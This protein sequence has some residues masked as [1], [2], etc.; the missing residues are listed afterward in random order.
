LAILIC[1]MGM[2]LS[3]SNAGA[4][5][6]VR[7]EIPSSPNPVGSG[8]RAMGMG[9]AFIAIAD[10][11]TAAS[12]NPGGLIQ[13]EKPE[14]S[15][16]G[17]YVYRS[18]NNSF[19]N[20][21]EASG[22][23]STD[24]VNLNYLSGAYP[25]KAFGHNMIVSLNYQRLYDFYRNW[26]FSLNMNGPPFVGPV[27]Y[28]YDQKGALYALGLAYSV[29]IMPSFS[30][31]LTINYWGDFIFANKWEQKYNQKAR[32]QLGPFPGTS[33]S[34][35]TEKY[36]FDGW[37]ANFGFLWRMTEHWTL[38]CVFKTPFTANVA[39]EINSQDTTVFPTF[40]AANTS[41][42]THLTF[43]DK[44]QMPMSYGLGLAYRF[45][46]K[47]TLSGDV[48]RTHWNDFTYKNYQGV[49]TSPISGKAKG[50]SSIAPTMWLRFGGEYLIIRE[51]YVVPLRAGI[52][53]DPAPAEGSP[54]KFY[55]FAVGSGISYG[56]FVFDI[57]YQFRFGNGVGSSTLPGTNFSQDVREHTVYSSLIIHF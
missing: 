44:L 39:H 4:Q 11:A 57:A 34:D 40:P 18:E 28:N 52:F 1:L 51:K 53:Y 42:T 25:F 56:R 3:F 31:G 12:W 23:Q 2:L 32:I 49:E 7:M 8:A 37:N 19:G 15:F 14:I 20:N 16:V 17:G 38:G 24:N 33:T 29:E 50:D 54:D 6:L 55:G 9:G 41:N 26:N 45:S 27:Q 13:L 46:D 22:S 21:P 47:F 10:D 5:V 48:Y 30:A 35:K 36:S 43:N